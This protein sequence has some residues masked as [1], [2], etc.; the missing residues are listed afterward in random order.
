MTGM[1]STFRKSK[2]DPELRVPK[3][4]EIR[5]GYEDGSI[6]AFILKTIEYIKSVAIPK[7]AKSSQPVTFFLEAE[8]IWPEIAEFDSERNRLINLYRQT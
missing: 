4:P 6:E 5:E 2:D 7:L 3:F 1:E 8:D